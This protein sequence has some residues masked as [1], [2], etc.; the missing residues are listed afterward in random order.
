MPRTWATQRAGH[1]FSVRR[2]TDQ[3][4]S[5]PAVRWARLVPSTDER[6]LR[7]T[8]YVVAAG[9]V[10]RHAIRILLLLSVAGAASPRASRSRRRPS[11]TR[12]STRRLETV[13]VSVLNGEPPGARRPWVA[14]S[15]TKHESLT[16]A[17]K[18]QQPAP[19]PSPFPPGDPRNPFTPLD[20]P[21]SQGFCP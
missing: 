3:F 18:F 15:L 12:S 4:G 13:T 19:G 1:Y 6:I 20:I 14:P 11:V 5:R 2:T 21:C 9:V 8:R 10:C 7:G 16:A 17:T